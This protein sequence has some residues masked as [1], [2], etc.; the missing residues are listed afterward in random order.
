MP[1]T[2]KHLERLQNVEERIYNDLSKLQEL[3]KI[4]PQTDKNFCAKFL[5]RFKRKDSVLSET[6]KRQIEELLVEFSDIFVKH[7]FDVGYNSEVTMK[8]DS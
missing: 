3:D 2:C 7:R 6:Q 8:L 5:Q 1:E 4:H